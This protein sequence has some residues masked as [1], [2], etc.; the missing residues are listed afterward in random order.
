MT[1]APQRRERQ[2]AVKNRS[3]ILAVAQTL[4]DR[5]G[6]ENVSMNRVAQEAGVGAGTLY[7]HFGNKS[8]LCFALIQ[9]QI[10]ALAGELEALVVESNDL[11]STLQ[12][13]VLRHQRFKESKAHLFKGM[14]QTALGTG[15]PMQSP[16]YE[17]LRNPFARLFERAAREEGLSCS[18]DATFRADV[19]LTVLIGNSPQHQRTAHNLSVEEFAAGICEIFYPGTPRN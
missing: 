8:D 7:R 16:V 14:L 19:L 3:L 12:E 4:F 1:E 13:M 6:V 15:G 11:R 18:P 5:D 10:V 2:D 17:T 9:D